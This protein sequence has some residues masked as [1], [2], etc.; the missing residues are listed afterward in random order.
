MRRTTV[1][2]LGCT[3]LLAGGIFLVYVVLYW[4]SGWA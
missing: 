1:A 4:L 3:A 2:D